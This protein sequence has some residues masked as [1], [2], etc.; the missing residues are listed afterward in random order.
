VARPVFR[1]LDTARGEIRLGSALDRAWLAPGEPAAAIVSLPRG[2]VA[3][4]Q[5]ASVRRDAAGRVREIMLNYEQS[6]DFQ[7]E[8]ARYRR[9]L[10]P[11]AVHHCPAD[12][13]AAERVAWR[14]AR[15]TFELVRD[16]RRSVSTVYGRLSDTEAKV[17]PG[18]AGE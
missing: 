4:A 18:P 14:D 7:A 3:G 17:R 15:T 16:P 12:P 5:S 6:T 2:L 13:E 10:G 8:I 9:E 11:P 1:H